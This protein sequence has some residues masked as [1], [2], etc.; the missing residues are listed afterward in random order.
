MKFYN[1][2]NLPPRTPSPAGSPWREKF[3]VTQNPDTGEWEK[4]IV[5]KTNIQEKIE[6]AAEATRIYNIIDKFENG[7]IG[8]KD[9]NQRQGQYFDATN[10]PTNVFD[11]QKQQQQAN[12]SFNKLPNELRQTLIEKGNI[13]EQ[14]IKNYVESIQQ[15]QV[16]GE[17]TQNQVKG[18]TTNE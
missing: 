4:V 2:Q 13:T 8:V 18:E 15:N 16:K 5:G 10:V 9:L 14:D 12:N 7:E 6:T 3:K 11:M 1:Q 17:T